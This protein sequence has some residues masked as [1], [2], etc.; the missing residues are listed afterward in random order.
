MLRAHRLAYSQRAMDEYAFN[1]VSLNV[2]RG[3]TVT[4]WHDNAFLNAILTWWKA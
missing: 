4:R 3:K 2:R 1:R